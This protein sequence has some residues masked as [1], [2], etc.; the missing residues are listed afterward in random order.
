M[1]RASRSGSLSVCSDWLTL[2]QAVEQLQQALLAAARL[3]FVVLVVAEHQPADAVV[4]AQRG[5]ADQA[6]AWAA[7]TDLN[8][9][10]EPKNSRGFARP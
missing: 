1:P 2:H 5:P 10:P 9:S 7:S 4:V 3:D 6:A 8:I